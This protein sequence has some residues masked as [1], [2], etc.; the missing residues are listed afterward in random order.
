MNGGTVSRCVENVTPPPFR[1]AQTFA[2]PRVTSWSVTFHPRAT[3]HLET[4]STAPLS[5][6]VEE[7]IV[8]SSAASATTSVM[9][10]KLVTQ[11]AKPETAGTVGTTGTASP[12]RCRERVF[13]ARSAVKLL[14]EH[15]GRVR[16]RRANPTGRGRRCSLRWFGSCLFVRA[17]GAGALL[18]EQTK[19]RGRR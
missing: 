8:R 11:R 12:Q 4:K 2:R 10:G 6:P 16:L 17:E 1:D 13:S 3:S 14:I 5:A 19:Q 15:E 9:R 7:S 18:G